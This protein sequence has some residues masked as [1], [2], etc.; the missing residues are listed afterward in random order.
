ML[1]ITIFHIINNILH[2]KDKSS[3]G[4]SEIVYIVWY[5]KGCNRNDIVVNKINNN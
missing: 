5:Y 3:N 2:K 4:F 1:R